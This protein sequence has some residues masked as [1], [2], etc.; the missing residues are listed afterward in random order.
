[1]NPN[2]GAPIGPDIPDGRDVQTFDHIPDLYELLPN[3][4]WP[5]VVYAQVCIHNLKAAADRTERPDHL[6]PIRGSTYYSIVGPRGRSDMALVGRGKPIPGS[7]PEAGARLFFT[8]GEVQLETGLQVD[9]PIWFRRLRKEDVWEDADAEVHVTQEDRAQEDREGDAR[10]ERGRA[11]Q[12]KQ[13]RPSGQEQEAGGGD[14]PERG[15]TLLKG[16]NHP[17][18]FGRVVE[19]CTG[20]ERVLERRTR[21]EIHGQMGRGPRA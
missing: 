16:H 8:D 10:V 11:S 13:A 9:S 12:R 5:G 18:N 14:S 4:G 17:P 21:K 1:M 20:C 6:R 3:G 7:A 19:G 2:L 15:K